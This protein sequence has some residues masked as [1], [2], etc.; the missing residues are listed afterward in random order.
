MNHG[1]LCDFA[2]RADLTEGLRTMVN[3]VGLCPA[4]LPLVESHGWGWRFPTANG[5]SK[6][7]GGTR[8]VI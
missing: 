8:G 6:F 7:R 4:L 3:V 2:T 1:K 5:I